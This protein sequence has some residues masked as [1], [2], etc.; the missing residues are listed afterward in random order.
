MK[1]SSRKIVLLTGAS[2]GLGLAIAKELMQHNKYLLIL[3]AR[4]NSL[5]RFSEHGITESDHLWIRE[6]DVTNR[7]QREKVIDEI[8]DTFGQVDFLI[9]NAGVAYRTVVE[10]IEPFELLR[11]MSINFYAPLDLVRLILPSMRRKRQGHIINISSVSG[12][13]A[14]PTMG[15]YS[16]SKFALEGLSQ[17]LWYEVRPWNIKVSLIEPGF[18]KSDAFKKVPWSRKASVVRVKTNCPYHPHYQN[19]E[20]FIGRI[21][22]K[23]FARPETVAKKIYKVMNKKNP[24][25]QV[26]ATLDAYFFSMMKRFVPS[27]IYNPLLY[28]LLP[29][30]RKWGDCSIVESDKVNFLTGLGEKEKMG[31]LEKFD[32]MDSS[33]PSKPSPEVRPESPQVDR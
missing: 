19:M 8:L 29:N 1:T 5:D 31:N 12:M 10:H 4:K 7:R 15:L 22:G 9:N 20:P 25:L 23:V 11:Q 26:P 33:S 14:M 6:M 30:I 21:M 24:P 27:R 16:C 17:S 13:L 2:V 3:T 18:I 28:R 32:F